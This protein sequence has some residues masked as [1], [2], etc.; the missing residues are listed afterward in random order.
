MGTDFT[1][2]ASFAGGLLIGAAAV[3]LMLVQGRILGATGIL[4][5]AILPTS[6]AEFCWR[7]AMLAGMVSAPAV[8][9]LL[10]GQMPVVEVPVSTPMLVIGGVLV[11]LGVTYGSG[12]T[13][14]HG[15]CGLARF[16]KRSLVATL[17]FMASAVVTVFIIRHVLGGGS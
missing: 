14:G 5:N 17:C 6:R 8:Y 1:P 7:A 12:C 4:R 9:Y 10:T 16:S 15:V 13:S 11:G 3:L 2:I